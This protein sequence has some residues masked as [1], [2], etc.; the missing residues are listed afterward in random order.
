MRKDD[1]SSEKS[2]VLIVLDTLLAIPLIAFTLV[3]GIAVALS[4]LPIAIG[5]SILYDSEYAEVWLRDRVAAS[6]NALAR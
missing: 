5:I 6:M 2:K 3:W 1:F 4:M